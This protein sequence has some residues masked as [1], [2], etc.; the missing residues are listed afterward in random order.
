MYKFFISS[1]I[2]LIIINNFSFSKSHDSPW[3]VWQDKNNEYIYID[4]FGSISKADIFAITMDQ[5]NC[6]YLNVE[7][8][9]T[10]FNRKTAYEGQKF[11]IEITE[12]PYEG[13][14]FEEYKNEIYVNY[15][16]QVDDHTV[17]V[18]SFD[19]QFE[20]QE[21][22]NKLDEYGPFNFYLNIVE[23]TEEQID[24]SI[25]F[26][27]TANLWDMGSLGKTLKN[28]YRNCRFNNYKSSEI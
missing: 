7:F 17:Y 15:Y 25:Y 24:P 27:H 16:E 4:S 1:F 10:S 6:D 21:W 14:N 9:I 22:I 12:T 23:H 8:F 18:L 3:E 26:E 11:L 13:E 28:E 20:T 19:H 5:K 2:F